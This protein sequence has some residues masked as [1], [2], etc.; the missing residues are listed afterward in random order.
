MPISRTIQ[1][2]AKV[3]V[4]LILAGWIVELTAI[5][6][7]VVMGLLQV[8]VTVIDFGEDLRMLRVLCTRSI[9]HRVGRY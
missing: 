9:L 1:T 5:M 2:K 6:V 8:V 7:A 3:T 4:K